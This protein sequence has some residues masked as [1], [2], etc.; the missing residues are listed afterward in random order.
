VTC[1]SE[2]R[3]RRPGTMKGCHPESWT[4][5]RPTLRDP[6]VLKANRSLMTTPLC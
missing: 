5:L 2:P 6:R 3:L 1:N 4:V